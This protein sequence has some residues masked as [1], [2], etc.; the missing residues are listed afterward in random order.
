MNILGI[1]TATGDGRC[2]LSCHSHGVSDLPQRL[3][4]IQNRGLNGQP[5]DDLL[6]HLNRYLGFFQRGVFCSE[7][8]GNLETI[9]RPTKGLDPDSTEY[10]RVHWANEV[11]N[12]RDQLQALRKLP[13]A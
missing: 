3:M 8:G 12:A 10:K 2:G 4:V 7:C 5:T 9:S 6:P 11:L 1:C 13:I